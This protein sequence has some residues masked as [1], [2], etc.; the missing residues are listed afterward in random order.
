MHPL[1]AGNPGHGRQRGSSGQQPSQGREWQR[2]LSDWWAEE[3]AEEAGSCGA[4]TCGEPGMR[5]LSLLK[6]SVRAECMLL[7][8]TV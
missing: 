5:H 3:E 8:G 1:S 2:H 7:G 4:M 6:F